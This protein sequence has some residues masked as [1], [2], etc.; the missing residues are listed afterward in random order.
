MAVDVLAHEEPK[1]ARRH[2][3]LSVIAVT[4]VA[5]VLVLMI[6][7]TPASPEPF[8]G[9]RPLDKRPGSPAG[10]GDTLGR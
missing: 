10:S 8:P 1:R 2:K 3:T 7:K 5:V 9:G 4:T 6:V